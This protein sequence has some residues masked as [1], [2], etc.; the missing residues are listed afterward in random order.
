M[1][2]GTPGFQSPEQLRAESLSESCDIYA[3]GCVL[4]EL[5]GGRSVWQGLTPF[6]IMCKVA[7]EKQKPQY[8]HL[9]VAVQE[10]V[11]RCVCNREDRFAAI[12]LLDK[13]IALF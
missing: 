9:P 4:I 8:D 11:S 10:V 6:Q 13:L 12:Q 7:V 1:K 3:F 5:F 2:A